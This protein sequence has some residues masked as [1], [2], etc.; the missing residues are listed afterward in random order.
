MRRSARAAGRDQ[1]CGGGGGGGGGE[2]DVAWSVRFVRRHAR[3]IPGSSPQISYCVIIFK[4]GQL[5]AISALS[6]TSYSSIGLMTVQVAEHR[7]MLLA[8]NGLAISANLAAHAIRQSYFFRAAVEMCI[9][10][11]A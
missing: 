7:R 11:S 4:Y 10:S 9:N 1:L 8:T 6:D 2:S 3:Y 5:L